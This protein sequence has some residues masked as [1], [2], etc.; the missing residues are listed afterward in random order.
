VMHE[1]NISASCCGADATLL[2]LVMALLQAWCNCY[3]SG[4]TLQNWFMLRAKRP[5]KPRR[6]PS[7]KR[8]I[9]AKDTGRP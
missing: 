7:L 8:D 3:K 9:A 4:A 2:L 6:G 5:G 1:A